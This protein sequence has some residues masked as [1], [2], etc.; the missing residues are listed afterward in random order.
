[1]GPCLGGGEAGQVSLLLIPKGRVEAAGNNHYDYFNSMC[2]IYNICSKENR[3]FLFLQDHN[4]IFLV[5]FFD[6]YPLPP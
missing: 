2:I 3:L 6:L 4:F 1:M 5:S